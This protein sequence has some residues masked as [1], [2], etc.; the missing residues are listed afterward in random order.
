MKKDHSI[1]LFKNKQVRRYWNA[2]MES[3]YFAIIDVVAI[4]TGSTIPKRYWSDLKS[5][6]KQEGS[7]VYEKIVQLKF[8]ARDGKNM[9]LIVSQQKIYFVLSNPSLHQKLSHLSCGWL[10]WL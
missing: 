2:D 9:Q 8:K 3:W 10:N 5:K 1:V 7:E 6:F 4:L